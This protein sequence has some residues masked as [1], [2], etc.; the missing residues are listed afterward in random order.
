MGKLGRI[1]RRPTDEDA[2]EMV[3]DHLQAP[4][5]GDR[6][7]KAFETEMDRLS[8]GHGAIPLVAAFWSGEW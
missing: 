4:L 2:G 6:G 5:D 1:D 8:S 3:D 7:R